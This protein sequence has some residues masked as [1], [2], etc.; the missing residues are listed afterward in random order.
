MKLQ[1]H[2][3]QN[4][5]I[6]RDIEK[7][8][9]TFAQWGVEPFLR[10]EAD[11][12][13]QTPSGPARLANR[14]AFLWVDNLQ[15]ELIQP[16]SGYV[17]FYTNELPADDSMRFHHV[18]S[19]VEDWDAFRAGIDES[20]LVLEGGHDH[21]RFCY[22]DARDTVGHYLEFNWMVPEMWKAIGG[23]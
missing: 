1:G 19:R 16:V 21:L 7:G 8:L 3:F 18:C 6:T 14:I 4:A 23:R 15:Y 12:E 13:I 9:A 20:S 17:D 10:H 22:I 5:Y 11:I 2:H